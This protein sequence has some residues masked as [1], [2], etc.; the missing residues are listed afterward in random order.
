M[1]ARALLA[2]LALAASGAVALAQPDAAKLYGEHCAACHGVDRLGGIG[3]ALLPE[4]LE[5]LRRPAAA[6][7]IA[8][9][10]HATQMPGF[11]DKLSAA[12]VD[13]LVGL[14]YASPGKVPAWGEAEIRASRIV[15][16]PAKPDGTKPNGFAA[17]S[18][19][20]QVA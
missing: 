14:I 15:H 11:D 13:A 8:K 18:R 17:G 20:S 9:G 4:S 5:R 2:G 7:V 19:P 6:Q 12:D 16:A 1:K 3:P 10:R